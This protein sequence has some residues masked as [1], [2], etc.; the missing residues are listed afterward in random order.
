M[1]ITYKNYI[2]ETEKDRFNLFISKIVEAKKDTK[3]HKKG[4]KI[5]TKEIVGWSFTFEGMIKRIILEELNKKDET[6]SLREYIIKFRELL[7]EIKNITG[8]VQDS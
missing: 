3:E 4:E 8:K 1:I 7:E 5:K 6:V 2:I